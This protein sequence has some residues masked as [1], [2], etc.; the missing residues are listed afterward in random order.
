M[1][2]KQIQFEKNKK[3][4]KSQNNNVIKSQATEITTGM[5][6]KRLTTVEFFECI[7]RINKF[8]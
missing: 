1:K 8:C 5:K 2:T 7:F 6:S 4:K 3:Q